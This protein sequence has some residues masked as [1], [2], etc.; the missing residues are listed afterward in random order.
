MN[1]LGC[2]PHWFNVQPGFRNGGIVGLAA[3]DNGT[4][5]LKVD[6]AGKISEVGWFLPQGTQASAAYWITKSIV[7]IVDY[8]RGIDIV[9]FNGQ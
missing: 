4:R 7:Y 9:R 6:S 3:Y 8:A 5:F 2:S 1:A